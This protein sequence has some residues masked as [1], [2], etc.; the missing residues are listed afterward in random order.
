MYPWDEPDN[1]AGDTAARAPT[2]PWHI[3]KIMRYLERSRLEVSATQSKEGWSMQARGKIEESSK[4]Y[5]AMLA[6]KGKIVSNCFTELP[7]EILEFILAFVPTEG[8]KSLARTSQGLNMTIPSSL[9]QYFWASRFQDSFDCSFVF[10]AQTYEHGIDWRS[11][12]FSTIKDRSS[13][14]QNRRR[15]WGLIGSLSELL[16]LQWNDAQGL[17]LTSEDENKPGWTEVHGWFQRLDR[18]KYLLSSWQRTPGPR[19]DAGCLRL[20]SQYISIPTLMRCIVVSTVSAGTATYITGLCFKQETK[21]CL[22]YTSR[23]QLSLETSG[24]RGFILAVGS[25]GIHAIQF[26]N[27]TGQLSQWFGNPEGVPITRRLVSNEPITAIK[28][29]F[30]VSSS[31]FHIIYC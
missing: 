28:A 19:I 12:Y 24:L 25:R 1:Y 9:G 21:I 26:V 14:I 7:L 29:G 5:P 17:L 6:T 8:V 4:Q 30:D 18:P 13:K 10:E 23:T 22:G 20:Y 15:I 16:C 3:P 11:L 2:N 31:G 27:P